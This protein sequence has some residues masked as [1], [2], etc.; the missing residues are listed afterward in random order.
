MSKIGE[1]TEDVHIV[2]NN[3]KTFEFITKDGEV[4]ELHDSSLENLAMD[5]ANMV[6]QL[7]EQSVGSGMSEEQKDILKMKR[8]Q[9]EF[10][11]YVKNQ[12]GSF[13]FNFYNRLL[14]KIEPQ[15]LTRFLYL[16]T[17]LDYEGRL[18]K[19]IGNRNVCIS[20]KELQFI[21][22]LSRTETYNTKVELIKNELIAINDDVIYINPRYCRK[23]DI[24]KNKRIE[25]IRMFDSSIKELYE[26]STK[27]E[28]KKL[29][30]LFQLLPYI[31]LRW[32]VICKNPQ[33]EILEEIQPYSIKE[34]MELLE[35]TNIT[36]FKKSLMDLSVCGE[37]VI[38][39]NTRKHGQLLTVN[40]KVYYK[41]VEKD[42]LEFLLGMFSIKDTNR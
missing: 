27:T 17:Y 39:I 5:T 41:G 29:S 33:E 40:P 8:E 10:Q 18:V 3:L 19:R 35:Q 24:M 4:V 36:R 6:I 31:N 1:W 37:D 15:F 7:V 30:L 42:E 34:L 38:M 32:N 26:I 13:Y 12:C 25:K 11:I 20:E 23:G 16:C 2:K 22:K 21:L 14:G 28:H 9:D